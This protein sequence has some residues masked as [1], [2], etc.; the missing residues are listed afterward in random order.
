MTTKKYVVLAK[1]FDKKGNLLSTAYNSYSKTHPIQ[2]YF[3]LKVGHHHCEYL[4]AEI[5]AIL[6][7]KDKPIYRITV[8]RYDKHGKAALAKPCVICNEA[9]KAYDI[10]VVE[11]TS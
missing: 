7:A 1:C 10:K 6:R 5:A 3:A 9:I 2:K 11:F 8:E 4:H